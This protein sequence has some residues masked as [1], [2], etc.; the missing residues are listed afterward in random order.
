MLVG[1]DIHNEH[2]SVVI[3]FFL[4][5]CLGGQWE[6]DDSIVVKLVSPGRTHSRIFWLPLELQGLGLPEGG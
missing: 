6:C 5:G 2:K 1:F 4:H 3:L